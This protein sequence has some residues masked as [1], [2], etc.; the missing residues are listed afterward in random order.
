M[1]WQS[2]RNRR[3]VISKRAT[4]THSLIAMADSEPTSE[5]CRA[6]PGTSPSR[7]PQLPPELGPF[8]LDSVRRARAIAGESPGN[9]AR[10]S[11]PH[12]RPSQSHGRAIGAHAG[13]FGRP[14]RARKAKTPPGG[15]GVFFGE[16][17]DR[18]PRA[19]WIGLR[20]SEK[21]QKR[22]ASTL[23]P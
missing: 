20:T 13:A 16:A 1:R 5:S 6:A 9:S 23:V 3:P 21:V 15:C 17:G 2:A 4:I 10:K 8:L 22:N 19:S 12:Q 7:R 11:H 18:G 14:Y